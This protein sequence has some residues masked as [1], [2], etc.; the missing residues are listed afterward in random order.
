[1][2]E[3]PV[4][5]KQLYEGKAKIIYAT[6]D[7]DIYI[8]HFKDDATAFNG[9]KKDSIHD[10]GITNNAV[11]SKIFEY[12]NANGIET[13]FVERISER[14]QL[15]RPVEIIP[16]E[17]IMRNKVAG[18]MARRMGLQEG[19]E[20]KHPIQEFSYKDDSLGDPLIN[21]EYMT[22][23]GIATEE[24]VAIISLEAERINE[25]LI[26]FFDKLG[27]ELIDFKLEFGRYKGKVILADE[28]S[29]DT[30]RFWDKATGEKLDKDR[31]R[32]DLGK[33]EESYKEVL[34]RVTGK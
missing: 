33:V 29:G 4:K 7:P 8:Q 13:H 6:S 16:A 28:V 32:H 26:A 24:E 15:V 23:L 21:T 34:E 11:S 9:E 3:I 14:E 1:M 10:K 22:A 2:G 18:S 17:V 27:I 5:G 25:L 19:T 20:L 12:L 31:F 30:C